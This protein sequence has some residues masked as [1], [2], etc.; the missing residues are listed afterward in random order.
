MEAVKMIIQNEHNACLIHQN[1]LV[2]TSSSPGQKSSNCAAFVQLS[3]LLEF[4]I[5]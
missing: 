5:T 3:D 1:Y 2:A 4:D